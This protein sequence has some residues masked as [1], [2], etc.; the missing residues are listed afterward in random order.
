M[1]AGG[2]LRVSI[3]SVTLLIVAI[4]VLLILATV[5]LIQVERPAVTWSGFTLGYKGY[6]S[7]SLFRSLVQQFCPVQGDEVGGNVT[8]SLTWASIDGRPVG[9]FSVFASAWPP[10]TGGPG[11]YV[12]WVN[13]SSRGG[14]SSESPSISDSLCDFPLT[15]GA[16]FTSNDSVKVTIETVYTFST[17]A[18]V[19]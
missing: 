18:P 7:H 4:A 13:N 6:P 17:M 12:Y 14:F 2:W 8:L 16:G 1:N 3:A 5:P 9:N 11:S 10:A 15:I 19:L